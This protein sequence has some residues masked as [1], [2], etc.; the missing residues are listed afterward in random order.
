V[1]LQRLSIYFREGRPDWRPLARFLAKTPVSER[2][3]VENPWT[4]LCLGYYIVGP[5]WL[6]CKRPDQREI[7]NLD[8][9]LDRLLTAWDRTQDGWLVLAAGPRSARLRSWARSF[10]AISFSSAEGD[11][12]AIIYRLRRAGS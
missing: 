3:F 6:C 12:G 4:Q 11:G 5:D 7:A 1:S 9:D 2:I 10:P 8:G